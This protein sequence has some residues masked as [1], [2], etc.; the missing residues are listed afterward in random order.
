MEEFT[1][2]EGRSRRLAAKFFAGSS[3][4]SVIVPETVESIGESCFRNCRALLDIIFST[5]L[6]TRFE[7]FCFAGSIVRQLWIPRT[8]QALLDSCF[9]ECERLEEVAFSDDSELAHIGKCAFRKCGLATINLPATVTDI[10]DAA[11]A[12][13]HDL[14][15]F[16]FARDSHLRHIG[17]SAFS[18]TGLRSIQVPANVQ[19]VAG[20]ALSS[21]NSVQ[22]SEGNILFVVNTHFLWKREPHSTLIRYFGERNSESGVLRLGAEVVHIASVGHRSLQRLC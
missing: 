12:D 3:I 22:L 4:T 11:F 6:L 8:V 17:K 5:Q 10:L 9:E 16:I 7:P 1:M 18:R 15:E 2:L 19:H 21:L 14:N 20:S 13:C